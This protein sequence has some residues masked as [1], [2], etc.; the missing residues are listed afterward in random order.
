M[1]NQEL[2]HKIIELM[3]KFPDAEVRGN[4]PVV[5]RAFPGAFHTSLDEPELLDA[6]E[7]YT[8]YDKS[9]IFGKIQPAVRLKDLNEVSRSYKHLSTFDMAGISVTEPGTEKYG[10][11]V[12]RIIRFLKDSFMLAGLDPKKLHLVLNGGGQLSDLSEGKYTLDFEFPR[13]NL[14]VQIWK[15]EGLTDSQFQ[16]DNTRQTFLPLKL[17]DRL[18]PWGYRTEILYDYHDDKIDLGTVEHLPYLPDFHDGQLVGIKPFKNTALASGL[19]LERLLLV[20]QGANHVREVDPVR[21][22]YQRVYSDATKHDP[23]LAFVLTDCLR[24]L[25]RVF[26]DIQEPLSFNRR[27]KIRKCRKLALDSMKELGIPYSKLRAYLELNAEAQDYYPELRSGVDS[28]LEY[29]EQKIRVEK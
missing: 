17:F 23:N 19:G 14:S 10:E 1:N 26:S 25:H 4:Y 21:T 2:R 9:L 18:T 24:T 7:G 5:N 11:R 12:K 20:N 8:N 3:S 13:D 16:F 6:Y 28:C 22:L 15:T 29:C 27:E